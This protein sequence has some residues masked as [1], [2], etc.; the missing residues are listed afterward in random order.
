MYI[1]KQN[2]SY[3]VVIAYKL[4]LS[5]VIVGHFMSFRNNSRLSIY[6]PVKGVNSC[7]S[8][9]KPITTGRVL[10]VNVICASVTMNTKF[11][12]MKTE[13]NGAINNNIIN[14]SI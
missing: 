9:V 13:M 4:P 12:G 5:Q 11:I 8:G 7:C 14:I 6:F 3:Y 10:L 1:A 2:K